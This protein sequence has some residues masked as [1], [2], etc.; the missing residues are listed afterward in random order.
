M[1]SDEATK[2]VA[3]SRR[4]LLKYAEMLEGPHFA[5]GDMSFFQHKVILLKAI[6]AEHAEHLTR[7]NQLVND[8]S[9]LRDRVRG[10]LH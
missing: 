6:A 3:L 8:W 5:H 2:R 4:T 9:E 7:I 10:S 1:T